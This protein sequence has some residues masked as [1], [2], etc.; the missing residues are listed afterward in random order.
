MRNCNMWREPHGSEP[1]SNAFTKRVPGHYISYTGVMQSAATET[2]KGFG[3]SAF[4]K[5]G[6]KEERRRMRNA[7][8]HECVSVSADVSISTAQ[9]FNARQYISTHSSTHGVQRFEE[10]TMVERIDRDRQPWPWP[11]LRA[12]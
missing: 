9:A 10:M 3:S 2:I 11:S 7:M 1:S 4:G 6:R 5:E 12:S 8:I